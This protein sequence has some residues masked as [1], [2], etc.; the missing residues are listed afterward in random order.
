MLCGKVPREL[1]LPEPLREFAYENAPLR[2]V[3][4]QTI[5]EPYIVAFIA[6]A[7]LLRGGEAILEIGARSGYVAAVLSEVTTDVYTVRQLGPPAREAATLLTQLG[8]RRPQV[9]EALK[10]QLKIGGRL[11]VPVVANLSSQELVRVSRLSADESYRR[12]RRCP[13][14][15]VD[16]G[17]R[18]I[19]R[20]R[21][22]T[23]MNF[24]LI[25][26][27]VPRGARAEIYCAS[28]RRYFS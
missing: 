8:D 1:F 2:I 27:S 25:D 6:E 24:R 22:A 13:F 18:V 10:R 15:T 3:G 20:R 9:P 4:Q 19:D 5:F 17:K 28:R 7:L 14:C 26:G 11:V 16:R 12:Y 23:T 21:R